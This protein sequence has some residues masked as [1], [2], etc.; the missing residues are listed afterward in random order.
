MPR[1]LSYVYSKGPGADPI[2]GAACPTAAPFAIAN[3]LGTIEESS[4]PAVTLARST[5]PLRFDE[6]LTAW[7]D[8]LNA[9]PPAGAPTGLY[10]LAYDAGTRRVTISTT[11]TSPGPVPFRPVLPGSVGNYLG[12]SSPLTGWATSWTGDASP[13]GVTELLGCTVRPAADAARVTLEEFR[14][15]RSAAVVWGNAATLEVR[16]WLAR[17]AGAGLSPW[18][19]TGRVRIVQDDLNL[20]P[21][22]PDN[23]GGFVDGYVVQT[24]DLKAHGPA[25]EWLSFDLLLAVP[26]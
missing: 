17:D 13:L 10:Q 1:I 23:L 7:K 4:D 24:S 9:D 16:V 14:H 18:T 3:T 5:E 11:N 8:S 12:F 21:W 25:E 26:R 20:D 6:L 19:T 22:A 2:G 15:G